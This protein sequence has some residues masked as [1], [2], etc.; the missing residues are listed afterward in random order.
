MKKEE[1][2]QLASEVEAFLAEKNI[3]KRD[4]RKVLSSLY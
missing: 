3:S 4:M 2:L 1:K